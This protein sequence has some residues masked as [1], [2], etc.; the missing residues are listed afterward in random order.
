M[1]LRSRPDRWT[2]RH[3]HDG[4]GGNLLPIRG[5]PVG[6][7]MVGGRRE[8]RSNPPGAETPL[9][10]RRSWWARSSWWSCTPGRWPSGSGPWR[11]SRWSVGGRAEFTADASHELRTPLSVIEAEVD[12]ALSRPRDADAYRGVLQRVAGEGRRLRSIVD[13]L[14]WLARVDAERPPTAE[15][16]PV[17][18]AARPRPASTGFRRWPPPEGSRWDSNAAGGEPALLVTDPSWIDRL[19]GVLVDN[20]CR[21]AD[22]GGVV[23]VGVRTTG[24]RIVLDVDDSGPGID[25]DDR[26]VVFDRFHRGVDDRGRNRPGPGHRRFGGTGNRGKLVDRHGSHRRGPD[27]GVVASGWG[28]A[29]QPTAARSSGL[30]SRKSQVKPPD[31]ETPG[32]AAPQES[33]PD[34]SFVSYLILTLLSCDLQGRSVPWMTWQIPGTEGARAGALGSVVTRR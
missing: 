6:Y 31:A 14:L 22:R 8:H 20:A 16:D 29:S 23:T 12:L 27:G 10:S 26:D 13:D 28:A 11:R 21:Y 15:R 19:I 32:P 5:N 2:G 30:I 4:R 33:G 9:S 7:R 24:T 17:D 1:R 18:V 34:L 3:H 25:P